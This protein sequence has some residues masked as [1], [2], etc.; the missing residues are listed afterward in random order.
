MKDLI[1][2]F[3]NTEWYLTHK[4]KR[5][6][7]IDKTFLR[8]FLDSKGYYIKKLPDSSVINELLNLRTF[9]NS[10]LRKYIKEKKMSSKNIEKLNM[11]LENNMYK[12]NII[13]SAT[14][15]EIKVMPEIYNWNWFISEIVESFIKLLSEEN[16]NRIKCC[17]N[18]ECKWFFYD[19]TKNQTKRWCDSKCA[20]LMKVRKFRAKK[21]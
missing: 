10:I 2:D 16:K 1:L 6:L 13:K 15:F 19:E 14:G 18:P 4:L 7:L 3:L 12:K 21:T 17:E 11:Y 9:L 5:E 8:Q 20:N